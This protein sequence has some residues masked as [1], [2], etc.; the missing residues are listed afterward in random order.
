TVAPAVIRAGRTEMGSRDEECLYC[1]SKC[2]KVFSPTRESLM[3]Q[4]RIQWSD[5]ID[6]PLCNGQACAYFAKVCPSCRQEYA[7]KANTVRGDDS[8]L[9]MFCP[10]C[11]MDPVEWI[12]SIRRARKT[13]PTDP[14]RTVAGPYRGDYKFLCGKCLANFT[15][16]RESVQPQLQGQKAPVIDCP[17]CYGR[18]CATQAL[19]CPK[20][21]HVYLPEGHT[22]T[23]AGVV[24]VVCPH[25]KAESPLPAE[26]K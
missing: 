15:P 2:N 14:P 10:R 13:S 5:A 17:L 19:C 9:R 21:K 24:K 11:G 4:V 7:Q 12:Q 8:V 1:C 20:C 23:V 25:C 22:L 18:Q 16:T 3:P 6:C 26:K